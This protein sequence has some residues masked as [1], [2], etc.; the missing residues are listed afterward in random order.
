MSWTSCEGI[1]ECRH[2]DEGNSCL[3]LSAVYEQTGMIS[4]VSCD[5]AE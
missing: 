3:W 2:L 1:Y 5:G 4:A